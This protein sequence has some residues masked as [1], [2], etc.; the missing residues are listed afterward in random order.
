MIWDSGNTLNSLDFL[1]SILFVI[2][3]NKWCSN[4]NS[5]RSVWRPK[6]THFCP[7]LVMS[8]SIHK[9]M[10]LE[11]WLDLQNSLFSYWL[12]MKLIV[13]FIG[14]VKQ[15]FSYWWSEYNPLFY[16]NFIY[17]KPQTWKKLQAELA[18]IFFEI[19]LFRGNFESNILYI[20][21]RIEEEKVTMENLRWTK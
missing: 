20:W 13:L 9:K 11:P 14:Q 15:V 19:T 2:H 8:F 12:M 18:D 4:M 16:Q 17:R 3:S 21:V 7:L 6:N 10:I 5:S 1:W